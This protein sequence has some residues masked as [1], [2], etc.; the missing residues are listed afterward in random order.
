MGIHLR[1]RG[2]RC[3]R[4]RHA[5]GT[6]RHVQTLGGGG[7]WSLLGR[8]SGLERRRRRDRGGRVRSGL[9]RRCAALAAR[10]PEAER[11]DHDQR[12]KTAEEGSHHPRSP[13]TSR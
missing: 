7:R 5:L 12:Q 11:A 1:R 10:E 9:R 6:G 3:L 4:G 8:W 2:D 13:S